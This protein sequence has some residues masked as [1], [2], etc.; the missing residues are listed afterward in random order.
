MAKSIEP[1]LKLISGYLKL[2]KSEN[3]VIPEYQRGYS[4]NNIT[5][6][7]KLWQDVE[8]FI[9][10][11]ASDP[12]FFG[13]IIVDVD[14]QNRD[15]VTFS[16]IDGQQRTTTFLLLLKAL[17]I[18]LNN[19]L[20]NIPNDEDSEALK[21]GLKANRN[22]I[23]AILYKADDEDIPSM[24][25]DETKIKN[26]LLI[27]N[28]SINELYLDEIKK[29]IEAKDFNEAERNVNKIP[30]KQNDNKYTNHF[31]NFCK[32]NFVSYARTTKHRI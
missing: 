13:T 3:F 7:D 31:R 2:D 10:S 28:K 4:W 12:Y 8:T 32:I 25:K 19:A 27:E 1:N 6:C 5:H 21:A 9:D 30:R 11:G 29:I 16:L 17:L 15:K 22:K 20:Q 26:I 18:R 14:D 23:M 24:L